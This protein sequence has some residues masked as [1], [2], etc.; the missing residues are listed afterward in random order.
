MFVNLRFNSRTMS[1]LLVCGL[2]FAAGVSFAADE[3]AVTDGEVWNEGVEYYRN[4]D[5]TNALR[6]LRPLMLSK[7]HGARAAEVVAKL[8]HERG[9]REE[10]AVAAQIALRAAP[11]DAKASRNFTRATD[12]LLEER[13]T[14]RINGILQASQGKDPGAQMQGA[15]RE[16][17]ALMDAAAGFRTNAPAK[18]VA[19]ADALLLR[20][21]VLLLD[22]FLAGLDR[23]M[24]KSAGEML[25]NAA[26]F[27]SV[28]VTGHEIEEFARW[29]TRFLVL[30]NGVI[31]STV[32]TAGADPGDLVGKVENALNGGAS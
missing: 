5:V 17:R 25:A 28:I 11:D 9:N 29:S 16:A 31:A 14:K 27:S 30:R 19:L 22:D 23:D 12:G 8:E 32:Q 21:R 10:A 26:A 1:A 7:T 20:P 6:V 13:E 15:A 18:A 24:R 4:N 2:A 3:G